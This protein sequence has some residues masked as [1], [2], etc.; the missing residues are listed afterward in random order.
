MKLI[1]PI[2]LGL[3]CIGLVIA[4]IL[5]NQQDNTQHDADASAIVDFS[6]LLTTS[7]AQI[8]TRDDAIL[9]LSNRLSDSSSATLAFSNHLMDAQSTLIL[10]MEHI[11]NLTRQV[12]E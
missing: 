7:Q 10:N 5:L 6:N 9:T 2:V 3:A 11:T 1:L 4:L 12:A 8:A